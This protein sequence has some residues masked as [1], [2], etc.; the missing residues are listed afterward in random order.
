VKVCDLL[1]ECIDLA[2]SM[3]PDRDVTVR[4]IFKCSRDITLKAD[5]VQL[6]EV[7][8]NVLNNA[9][10]SFTSRKGDVK[11]TV[12]VCRNDQFK[13]V[14]KNDGPGIKLEVLEHIY[15]PFHSTKSKGT[16]LGLPVC[17]QIVNFHNG[18]LDVSNLPG[19]GVMVT[20]C[21]PLK[22]T[23]PVKAVEGLFSSERYLNGM[24]RKPA[25][26]ESRGVEI[27]SSPKIQKNYRITTGKGLKRACL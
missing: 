2:R 23:K 26:D 10:E 17:K 9:Y 1:D 18:K 4:R 22:N 15:E 14:F 7:F 21:L 11:I 27:S 3:F 20:I 12:S 6:R 8:T 24:F 13:I 25:K 16:G 5:P 19:K